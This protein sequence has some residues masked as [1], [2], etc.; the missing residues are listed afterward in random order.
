MTGYG[1]E[2]YQ[3]FKTVVIYCGKGRN[4]R[5]VGNPDSDSRLRILQI[6]NPNINH[7]DRRVVTENGVNF[8]VYENG[9]CAKLI[10]CRHFSSGYGL[11]QAKEIA[12]EM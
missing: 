2:F 7:T 5:Y 8:D 10:L 1:S 4:Y 3:D 11:L 9:T 12:N 6:F